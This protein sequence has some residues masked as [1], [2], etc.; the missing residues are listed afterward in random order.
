MLPSPGSGKV[1]M[2]RA[3]TQAFSAGMRMKLCVDLKAERPEMFLQAQNV[4]R[5]GLHVAAALIALH[6]QEV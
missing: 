5:I 1:S 3:G 2:G 6:R 4:S